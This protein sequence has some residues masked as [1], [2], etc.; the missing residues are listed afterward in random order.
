MGHLQ[1]EFIR[2]TDNGETS[3]TLFNRS[4]LDLEYWPGHDNT[5]DQ[6]P[7][8]L[9]NWPHPMDDKTGFEYEEEEKEK[10]TVAVGQA[11]PSA[12]K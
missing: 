9:P 10:D 5:S 11:R 2:K 7:K 1:Y 3:M 6:K 8:K 4:L 12:S